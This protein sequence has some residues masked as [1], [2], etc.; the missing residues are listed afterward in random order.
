MAAGALRGS[1]V[2][3]VLEVL[4]IDL[5]AKGSLMRWQRSRLASAAACSHL[6]EPGC[7]A[8]SA[9]SLGEAST[10]AL[11]PHL[12]AD[13]GDGQH[14]LILRAPVVVLPAAAGALPAS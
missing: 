3:E 8:Q 4:A 10:G 13:A 2:H 1:P 14:Q 12:C 6:A 11:G 9:A 7:A 5:H